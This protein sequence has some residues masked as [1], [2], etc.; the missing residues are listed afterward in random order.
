MS[1]F[2]Y[3]LRSCLDNSIRSFFFSFLSFSDGVR[4]LATAYIILLPIHYSCCLLHV[5]WLD[6]IFI[7]NV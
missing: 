5:M 4:W 7:V 6:F 3:R 1:F 2:G